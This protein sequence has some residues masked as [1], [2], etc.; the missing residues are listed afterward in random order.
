MTH[1]LTRRGLISGLISTAAVG[2]A[3]AAM[4]Q[5]AFRKP[6]LDAASRWNDRVQG[7]IFSATRLAQTYGPDEITSPF[8]FNA[9][10]PEAFSPRVDPAT[11]R[12]A[13]S[14]RVATPK[15]MSL[16]DLRA[17]HSESQ[18]TR[19][20]CIEGWSAIGEWT[21]V[22]L[23]AVL[24]SVGADL[25]AKYVHFQCAD[26]YHSS[27]DMASA[28]HPQTILALD[29]LGR[30][31]PTAFGAPCRLRIPTKLGFKNAKFIN[32]I[33]VTNDYPGGYW[34]DQGYNWFAGL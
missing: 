20:I 22:P 34:E 33:S 1:H 9:F 11:W 31:L 21:G 7:Q 19:L 32:A 12:L 28:L 24:R 16:D 30:P 10:Y 3:G 18:I 27:I 25:S 15:D 29:F 26:D 23:S 13:I 2:A 6:V 4:T 14:G 17:F 5:P 8:R